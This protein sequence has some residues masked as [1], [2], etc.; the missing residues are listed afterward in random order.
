M[1]KKTLRNISRPAAVLMALQL[2][3]L[4]IALAYWLLGRGNALQ[5]SF[6]AENF[7]LLSGDCTETSVTADPASGT[8]GPLLRTPPQTLPRGS[9]RVTLYYQAEAEGSGLSVSTAQLPA[10]SLKCLELPLTPG[11]F[12]AETD[13]E[14]KKAVT[15][16]TLEVSY[17]G[18]GSLEITGLSL[19]RTGALYRKT[20]FRA[21]LLCLLADLLYL[22][23]KSEASRRAVML[24]LSG[25][26]L[27]SCYPLFLDYLPGGHD[28][29]FHLL[30]IEGLAKGLASGTFPVKIYPLWARDYGYAVGVL[31]GDLFLYFPAL[32]RLL[33]YSLQEAYQ[34]YVAAVNLGTLLTAY[35]AFRKI[36]QSPSV[37]VSGAFLYT[38][39]CYR[40]ADTYTRASLGEYTAMLFLPLVLLGFYSAL[41]APCKKGRGWLKQGGL[42]ALGLSGLIY[43]HVLSCEMAAFAIILLCLLR[44]PRVFQRDTF[45]ALAA[46][47]VLT[48]LFSLGFLVPFLDYLNSGLLISSS[49]W[50]GNGLTFFQTAGLFPV[51][52]FSLFQNSTGGSW[53]TSAG[54]AGEATYSLGIAFFCILGLFLY[55]LCCRRESCLAHPCFR[56]ACLC[57][58]LGCLFAFMSICLFPWDTIASWG[59]V[60]K[61]LVYSL[62]F[63]WRLLELS[64]LLFT[65]T[66]CF[67][68][69][70]L[71]DCLGREVFCAVVSG[72]L[73]LAV[74]N[75][76]WYFFD[77]VYTQEPYRVYNT[78]DLNTMALYSNDYLPQGT[79]TNLIH[80]NFSHWEGVA[81]VEGYSKQG[82]HIQCTVLGAQPGGFIDFPLISYKYYR[83]IRTDTGEALPVSA[84]Y[85]NMLRVTFP[86]AFEGAVEI[87]FREP[88]HWQAAELLSLLSAAGFCVWLLAGRSGFV[89][90]VHFRKSQK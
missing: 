39:S 2:V 4:G 78:G 11:C 81:Q 15:D 52:L 58:G 13:F 24:A 21:L 19:V 28:L 33:G 16:L 7:I 31:Y 25:I 62:E 90:N 14:L 34:I 66:G 65:F 30:R 26:F 76:G 18:S 61:R 27:V 22:F 56:A 36:F 47:A 5:L 12:V 1:D 35:L 71:R 17:S 46:G 8:E 50:A 9:Y 82:T 72:I 37:G 69:S 49:E 40:L 79:D 80:H 20:F 84:G 89:Q 44:L 6:S 32:L 70:V 86:Y 43:S 51:Q 67:V 10:L 85:N 68:F 73:V 60:A 88:W 48:V 38:L 45:K 75:I 83:C 53:A 54:V 74:V 63:P 29:P 59:S 3:L 41:A 55:L 23:Y 77:L 42:I 64:T 87:S 57:T